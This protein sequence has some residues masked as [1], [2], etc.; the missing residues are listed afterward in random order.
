MQKENTTFSMPL[1][2]LARLANFSLAQI[3]GI[4]RKHLKLRKMS[5]RWIPHLL[6]DEQKKYRVLNAKKLLKMFP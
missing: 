4:L 6:T 1:N 5:A 3:Q 2:S